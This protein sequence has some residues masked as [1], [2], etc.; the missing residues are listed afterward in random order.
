VIEVDSKVLT[1]SEEI[2]CRIIL[3]FLLILIAGLMHLL[4][5]KFASEPES[6]MKVQLVIK[7]YDDK[8]TRG[9]RVNLTALITVTIQRWLCPLFPEIA[10]PVGLAFRWAPSCAGTRSTFPK[11]ILFSVRS[12]P[13]PETSKRLLL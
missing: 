1:G 3:S 12:C 13:E 9:N 7:S 8:V 4:S 5:S 11:L 10:R 6:I 2:P